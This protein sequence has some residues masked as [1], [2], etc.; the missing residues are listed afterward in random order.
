L[1]SA[2]IDQILELERAFT[3]HTIRD[4]RD[5][6]DLRYGVY[7]RGA[8]KPKKYVFFSNGRSEW[9]EKYAYLA[10]DL[11][12]DNDTALVMWDHRGQ[13]ASGGTPA[14][15]DDYDTYARD[16]SRIVE[17]TAQDRPYIFMSHSMG[18]LIALYTT[19]I[20]KICP[21]AL[22]LGSPL[23][24][25]PN[26]PVPRPMA[27]PL[28]RLLTQIGL[29][30]VSSGAGTFTNQPFESNN[31][32]QSRFLYERIQDSPLKIP[33]A[34]FE[35]V[36]ATFKAID[37]VFDPVNI[38]KLTSPTLILGGTDETV[39]D[40]SAFE[41]WVKKAEGLVPSP[42]QLSLIPRGRHELF[43]EAP[44]IYETAIR[45]ATAWMRAYL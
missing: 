44:Q 27:K 22:V 15:I 43:S 30:A 18:G 5:T 37:F 4:D 10:V 14:W 39:V 36:S 2:S 19:L 1:T 11:D 20:G 26:S 28:S 13:G 34:T 9:L 16:T 38:S 17:A 6:L 45:E 35:W 24:G 31:L 42:V 33:G 32:T 12:L 21:R 8:G 25:L 41:K 3:V 29:G 7:F 23:L 40:Q